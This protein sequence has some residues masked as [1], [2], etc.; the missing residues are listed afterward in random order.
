[1]SITNDTI[2][3][4]KD[5]VRTIGSGFH[6]DTPY[7]DYHPPLTTVI[8]EGTYNQLID[9][10]FALPLPLDPYEIALD[11]IHDLEGPAV[12]AVCGWGTSP[13]LHGECFEATSEPYPAKGTRYNDDV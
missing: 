7:E 2:R 9:E 8:P 11:V 6:P 10:V 5:L 13:I 4:Y 12:C 1:M 3:R